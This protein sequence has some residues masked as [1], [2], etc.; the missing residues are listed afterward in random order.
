MKGLTQI[1][2]VFT[3]VVLMFSP[4]EGSSNS[5]VKNIRIVAVDTPPPRDIICYPPPQP[6]VCFEDNIFDI[7]ETMPMY[8]GGEENLIKYLSRK[9][10]SLDLTPYHQYFSKKVYV[11]LIIDTLGQPK[12]VKIVKG[13]LDS[14]FNQQVIKIIEE[15]PYW[16]PGKV[17]GKAV[18]T[19]IVIPIKFNRKEE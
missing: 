9:T 18:N 11:E 14:S 13:G 3:L 8:K 10:D 5:I 6:T 12:N 15:M 2:L 4:M 7:P 19:M 1:F 17:I 16:E